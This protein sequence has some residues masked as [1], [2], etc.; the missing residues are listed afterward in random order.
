VLKWHHATVRSISTYSLSGWG[1]YTQILMDRFGEICDEP[2]AE[3]MKLRQKGFITEYQ[4][5]FDA[6]V[7]RL[8]LSEEYTLSCF[9][10]GLKNDIQILVTMFQPQTVR[11]L[12]LWLNSMKRPI[13]PVST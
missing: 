1:E 12:F 2:M 4:E 5:E 10:G 6:I 11:K 7:T 9:L 8:D 3:L 13:A